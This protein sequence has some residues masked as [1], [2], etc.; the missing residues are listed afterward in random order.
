MRLP[1]LTLLLLHA[2]RTLGAQPALA[3]RIDARIDARLA[4]LEPSLIAFRRDLHQHPEPS[5]EE[6]RTAARVAA[7]LR[8]LGLEVRTGVGG[9]GVVAVL[10]GGKPGPVVA[11]RADL[12]AVRTTDTDPVAFRSTRPGVRHSCG[13]DVHTTIGVA[14]ATALH[15]VRTE[16]PGT[17]VFLFQPAEEA[18]TGA[19]AMLADPVWLP[20]RPAAIYALH[21]APLPVGTLGTID[22]D[23]MAGRDEF[24][25]VIAGT[26]DLA[27]VAADV[28]QR[29]ELLATVAP[30]EAL[31]PSP[32]DLVFV[33]P[34]TDSV[35]PRVRV[36]RGR[37][38]ATSRSRP[39]VVAAFDALRTLSRADLRV[40]VAYTP[41]AIAG[42][43]NDSALTARA[44]LAVK[45]ALGPTSVVALNEIVP[46]FSEDFGSFQS[47]VPGVFFFLGVSNPARGTVG[48]PHTAAYVADEGAIL[49]GA[50]AMAAVV[51]ERLRQ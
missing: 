22:G 20:L 15:A 4:A 34:I 14:L 7:R 46:A 13:H 41:K 48:M 43:T 11:F 6:R 29:I 39:R 10:R 44:I 25:V 37:L 26:G 9:F 27:A 23:L 38:S 18:A 51:L 32:S 42:V 1:L 24:R 33:E 2:A 3:S 19:N 47:R 12:D 31:R 50:R 17:V 40:D 35:A 16:L 8:Q 5:G 30:T 49:V 45:A 21:T 28:R 36:L